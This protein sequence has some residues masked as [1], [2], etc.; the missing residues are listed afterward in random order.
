VAPLLFI[1]KFDRTPF[2]EIIR[3]R[4]VQVTRK[5]GKSIHL[6]GDPKKISKEFTV[7][8]NPSSLNVLVP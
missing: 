6:D 4:E 1:K 2:I 3:A 7:K 8:I 5:K